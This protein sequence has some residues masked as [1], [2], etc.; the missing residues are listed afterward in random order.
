MNEHLTGQMLS[1]PARL[2][3]FMMLLAAM[4]VAAT[5]T[6]GAMASASADT[7]PAG[8]WVGTVEQHGS[9]YDYVG[10]ACPVEVEICIAV[11]ARYRIYPSTRQ[12]AQAL[13]TVAGGTAN[14]EGYLLSRHDGAHSGFLIV[15]RVTP[16]PSPV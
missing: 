8:N 2:R 1:C 7:R 12:A 16:A 11:E 13:P 9:H 6:G 5:V 4:F 14:L 3:R 10:R 15:S